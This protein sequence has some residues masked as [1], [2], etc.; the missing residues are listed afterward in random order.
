MLDE[1]IRLRQELHQHP[2][3][4]HKETLT[5][6]RI[7]SF[8]SA[9]QPSEIITK[10]G[11]EGLAVCY[12]YSEVGPTVAIRCELDALP[13]EE[14]NQLAYQS[15]VKGVSH[16]C[17]HDGHMAIV[18]G[19]SP[20]LREQNFNK[21]K[22]VLLFQPAEEIGK[23][24]YD[25]VQDEKLASL[26]ID[27]MFALHNIPGE[28]KHSIITMDERFSAE[29]ISCSIKLEG[30]ESHAAEP[31]KGISPAAALSMLIA[32]LSKLNVPQTQNNN[33]AVLTPVYMHM[34][35]QAYGISPALG[36]IH[37]T[38]RTW[39]AETMAELRSRI[40]HQVEIVCKEER[41]RFKLEWFEHF[42]A[43]QNNSFC[44]KLVK[45]AARAND[46]DVIEK[47][48]PFK[49]GEDFGW[50]SKA[51]KTAMFGLGAGRGTPALHSRTY[52]F[53]DELIETGVKMFE[54]IITRLLE[55]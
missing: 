26:G 41:L 42:A 47:P 19:L 16:K 27:Y 29:V 43:A 22:V 1:L 12:N 30:Q 32:A 20:W 49:F 5:A 13:I 14:E 8:V 40:Q 34:G 18:A 51:Y 39:S 28:K 44:N 38:I 55:D 23:G 50:F 36:E 3:L 17:G 52:D 54:E 31:E 11:G 4:S 10:I 15:V 37:Y 21:G 7:Y 24:A 9:H 35:E 2:E 45:Q 46:F 53:P 48:H 25:M 6:Q 33:Y